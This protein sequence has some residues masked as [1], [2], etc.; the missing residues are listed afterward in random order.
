[1]KKVLILQ[2]SIPSYRVPV[3]N[4]VGQSV[5]L[6]VAHTDIFECNQCLKFKTLKLDCRNFGGL[7]RINQNL[8]VI[9][10]N[11][12]VVI[13]MADLHFISYCMLPFL[14]RK[15]K[16]IPWTIGIRASYKK[17]YNVNRKKDFLDIIYSKILRNSDAIL[18]YMK[19]PIRFWKNYIDK[20]KVFVAHNTVGIESY[21][22]NLKESRN[23]VLF[24]GTL[25]K[26]KK[27]Y[28]LIDAYLKAKEESSVDKFLCLDIVGDGYEYEKIRN[29]ISDKNVA[30][31]IVLHGSIYDEDKLAKLF[32]KAI[33]CVS[34]D[35]AGLSVLKSMGYGV[36]FV[37][38]KN[39]ITGG[40]RLNILD[41]Q[42]GILYDSQEELVLT[43]LDAF[44]RPEKYLKLG[45]NARDHY[46]NNA[47]PAKMANGMISA[48]NYVLEKE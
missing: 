45:E 47:T 28:E 1:M 18:F 35:Q 46:L 37:T 40:E 29:L 16:V 41:Q 24:V 10:S 4:I 39:A 14:R 31:S 13:F 3:F 48:I 9:C 23:R 32:S 11:F 7:I 22:K 38:R 2:K 12:D 26:E 5:D 25:Y 34:P 8:T 20:D 15:F 17:R 44:K 30:N 21:D 27:V 6:T 19:E 33:L 42:N 43:L 36:P